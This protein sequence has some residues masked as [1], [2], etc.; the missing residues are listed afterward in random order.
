M[1]EFLLEIGTEEIPAR[2]LRRAHKDLRDG[3]EKVLAEA[4]L[5]FDEMESLG[6]PR[7]LVVTCRNIQAAQEDRVETVLG[8]PVKIAYDAAGNP[9][10]AL[11][12]FL[13]ANAGLNPD[14]LFRTQ[15]KKGEVVA[16]KLE[17]KG[18]Q[19]AAILAEAIPALLAKLHFPK[20]MR[21]GACEEPFIRPVRSILALFDGAVIPFE[22]AG[23]AAANQS[24]GHRFSGG[25]AF[26]V[27]AIDTYFQRKAERHIA[28]GHEEREAKIQAQIDNYLAQINGM[29][30]ADEALL[31]EVT[32]L[33]ESPFVVLGSFDEKFL[34]I[35]REVLITS[36][37]EHQKSFTVQDH[38]GKLMP[39]F[40]SVASVPEDRK[41]LVRKGNEWV[42]NARLYDAKFF[43]ETDREKKFED[44]YNKLDHVTFI[45]ELGSYRD[46]ADR[47][48]DL[49]AFMADSLSLSSVEKG[50][51]KQ[52]AQH[53][54]SDLV[55]D[56]VFEF[57]ELQGE[58][59]GLLMRHQGADEP[60][61]Q[62]IY[63]HYAP[64]SMDDDLPLNQL[65]CLI[66]VADKLDTL[67]GC[68]A[69]GLIPTG[70]KD[71]YALRRAAQGIIRILVEAELPLDLDALVA[72]SLELY[73]EKAGV[74]P[75]ENLAETLQQFCIER[76]RHY[77]RKVRGFDYD[78]VEGVLA[79][80]H[81]RVD[82][83]YQRASAVA[84]Q[85]EKEDFRGLS[86]SLKRMKNVIADESDK[87]G[88]FD[89]NLLS[90]PA[91][92]RFWR[93]YTAVRHDI[94][95]AVGEARYEDA[96]DLMVTLAD[97]AE[98][99]FGT[100][101]VYINVDEDALRLNRKAM[102]REIGLTLGLVADISTLAPK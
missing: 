52:A 53:A 92:Q 64:S 63:S 89:E 58:I 23:V 1:A 98:A 46:K 66:S 48:T 47:L 13:R 24:F 7:Q 22:F 27:D 45:Q 35:P 94:E 83:V 60:V 37:R 8:P 69:V 29:L 80:G 41:G 49:T 91:E 65:G 38:H 56:L 59:G 77:L 3:L 25:E 34:D 57:A 44:L 6:A 88:D 30:V 95:K 19:T 15:G 42:L 67:V 51:L 86:L 14:Q 73:R 100:D 96:M 101:G 26:A 32:D 21:W 39:Y 82:Q 72:K 87:L 17:V 75:P 61:C 18:R 70:S 79:A 20:K 28:V 2:M 12:G 81:A 50:Q 16:G 33:V 10:K 9:S 93:E 36:M 43:W 97:P 102:C 31:T 40:L 54:K 5:E 90:D 71:P 99:Y 4:D 76:I 11:Q 74:T 85:Q 78:V 68:F 84:E 62:A 55:S